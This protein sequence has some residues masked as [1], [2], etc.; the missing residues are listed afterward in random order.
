MN[1]KTL[2][3]GL[4]VEELAWFQFLAVISA[5][6]LIISLVYPIQWIENKYVAMISSGFF[7]V[8]IVEWSQWKGYT[9]KYRVGTKLVLEPYMEKERKFYHTIPEIIALILI[10]LP[11]LELISGVE[12]IPF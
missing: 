12:L 3:S 11:L 10:I 1:V 5:I 2:P 8:A 4:K 6:A 7:L 9:E